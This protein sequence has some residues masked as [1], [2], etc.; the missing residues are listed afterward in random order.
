MLN[1]CLE[2][3]IRQKRNERN[4]RITRSKDLSWKI[5][6]VN[7]N[8]QQRKKKKLIPPFG[9]KFQNKLYS[10]LNIDLKMD[11]AQNHTRE[12]SEMHYAGAFVDKIL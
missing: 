7:P 12:L 1:S 9:A 5:E 10:I 3:N 6:I 11:F 8:T 2:P 4:M